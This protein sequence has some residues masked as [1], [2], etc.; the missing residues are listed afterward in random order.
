MLNKTCIGD[1]HPIAH[2]V[3]LSVASMNED[4]EKINIAKYFIHVEIFA[5]EGMHGENKLSLVKNPF[6]LKYS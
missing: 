3:S 6:L 1:K 4:N 2:S 5:F